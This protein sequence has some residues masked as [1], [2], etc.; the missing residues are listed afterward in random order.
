MAPNIHSLPLNR[1]HRNSV[2]MSG[3]QN[4]SYVLLNFWANKTDR[5]KPVRHPI[6]LLLI[7]NTLTVGAL[8]QV[9]ALS[10]TTVPSIFF[11]MVL[12]N[13]LPGIGLR[14]LRVPSMRLMMRLDLATAFTTSRVSALWHS[15]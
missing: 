14:G 15:T 4:R 11:R 9:S 5:R 8:R 13:P 12:S 1:H 2:A 7:L 6:I 3:S 10:L